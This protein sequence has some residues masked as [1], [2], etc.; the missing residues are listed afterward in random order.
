MEASCSTNSMCED[1]DCESILPSSNCKESNTEDQQ[2]VSM[3]I[4]ETVEIEIHEDSNYCSESKKA[5]FIDE[6][7]GAP[8][9]DVHLQDFHVEFSAID[10]AS[11]ENSEA[12]SGENSAYMEPSSSGT[13]DGNLENFLSKSA[14]F[15][16]S[17]LEFYHS[18]CTEETA[19]SPTYKRSVSLPPSFNFISAMKGGRARHGIDLRSDLRVKWATDVYDPPVSSMLQMVKI[20][21]CRQLKSKKFDY[22]WLNIA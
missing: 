14:T 17:E 9:N 21:N 13:F 11:D 5:S 19:A 22:V 12:N 2:S 6:A 15:P 8:A 18:F 16:S 4:K 20:N 1:I 7:D 10:A 3:N